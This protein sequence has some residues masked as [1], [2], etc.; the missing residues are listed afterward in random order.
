MCAAG[1]HKAYDHEHRAELASMMHAALDGS[2]AHLTPLG[3][4]HHRVRNQTGIATGVRLHNKLVVGT[5]LLF[6]SSAAY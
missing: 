3:N 5:S 6:L 2:M 1:A 4:Y